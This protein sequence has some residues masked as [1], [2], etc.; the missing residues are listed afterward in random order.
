M[1]VKI[2]NEKAYDDKFNKD[3]KNYWNKL[4]K[5]YQKDKYKDFDYNNEQEV[6][7]ENGILALDNKTGQ[8]ILN[9]VDAIL[10]SAGYTTDYDFETE[11]RKSLSIIAHKS[12]YNKGNEDEQYN[13]YEFGSKIIERDLSWR[14]ELVKKDP[15]KYKNGTY[16][17][18]IKVQVY[19]RT[20]TAEIGNSLEKSQNN[21]KCKVLILSN[22]GK[23]PF[24]DLK[25]EYDEI[26]NSVYHSIKLT[27]K[28]KF[29]DV[30]EKD[31]FDLGDLSYINKDQ[32]NKNFKVSTK[33]KSKKKQRGKRR[34]R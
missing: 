34:K 2:I 7:G 3:M 19:V 21:L 12:Y 8:I 1:A 26:V 27:G 31:I 11:N 20:I 6:D 22:I 5:E 13:G 15:S 23:L 24:N 14:D 28:E 33:N 18:E 9:G 4:N 16:K 25:E 17:I 30:E 32:Q 10:D 29:W